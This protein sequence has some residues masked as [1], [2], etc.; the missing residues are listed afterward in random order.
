MKQN[1][2]I[3][4]Q[5]KDQISNLQTQ[6]EEENKQQQSAK[7]GEL[8]HDIINLKKENDIFKADNYNSKEDRLTAMQY[9][10]NEYLIKY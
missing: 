5:L 7:F 6:I 10:E 9:D 3:I 2:E 1:G 8:D 4:D